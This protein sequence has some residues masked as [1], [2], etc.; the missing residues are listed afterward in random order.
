MAEDSTVIDTQP[1]AEEEQRKQQQDRTG[2]SGGD[3]HD[4]IFW[5]GLCAQEE[6]CF[7]CPDCN[8]ECPDCSGLDCD[9]GLLDC[10]IM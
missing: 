1:T 7:Q 6:S 3:C 2:G 5:V 10:T 8:C 9:C 4:C